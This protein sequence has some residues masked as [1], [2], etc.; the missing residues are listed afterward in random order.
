M[1]FKGARVRAGWRCD[2]V[3]APDDGVESWTISSRGVPYLLPMV[4]LIFCPIL[5]GASDGQ[6]RVTWFILAALAIGRGAPQVDA[7]EVEA[8]VGAD[9]PGFGR[10]QRQPRR[11]SMPRTLSSAWS[12]VAVEQD[13]EVVRIADQG[14]GDGGLGE[15]HVEAVQVDVRQQR[16]DDPALRRAGAGSYVP[17]LP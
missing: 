9:H 13:D 6:K 11:P 1:S 4:S 14:A 10:M 17:P 15:H 2:I 3:P 12:T 7:E 8:V 5:Q 16:R